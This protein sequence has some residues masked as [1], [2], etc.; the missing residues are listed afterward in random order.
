M[1]LSDDTRRA[2][3]ERL[4]SGELQVTPSAVVE[5]LR[6]LS[7][8]DGD[9]G[10]PEIWA[11]RIAIIRK[12]VCFG[13]QSRRAL[14]ILRAIGSPE[15]ADLLDKRV[16]VSFPAIITSLAAPPHQFS[17]MELALLR[18]A[19]FGSGVYGSADVEEFASTLLLTP[20]E[21]EKLLR[22]VTVLSG[23]VADT[24]SEPRNR[25][26]KRVWSAFDLAAGR[27][28]AV[29]S[30]ADVLRPGYGSQGEGTIDG[31][32]I[33]GAM[34]GEAV[35]G[36]GGRYRTGSPQAEA[37]NTLIERLQRVEDPADTVARHTRALLSGSGRPAATRAELRIAAGAYGVGGAGGAVIPE[38][39]PM[40]LNPTDALAA[41]KRPGGSRGQAVGA[42]AAPKR[43]SGSF[44]IMV[45]VMAGF[46][47]LIALAGGQSVLGFLFAFVI[48]S[49]MVTL[50]RSISAG[51][52]FGVI[53]VIGGFIVGGMGMAW[54]WVPLVAGIIGAIMISVDDRARKRPDVQL[55]TEQARQAL[56]G[57]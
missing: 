10:D 43:A 15:F 27:I 45:F 2:L 47:G 11:K 42:P 48:A 1:N 37:A 53:G 56:N 46:G 35:R 34:L 14:E 52:L 18:R 49:G 24:G 33:D 3:A 4:F 25:A 9:G 21:S 28:E 36:L 26:E 55:P 6:G 50:Y 20:G 57:R 44:A 41:A 51:W 8:S 38:A 29:H 40:E 16:G 22:G 17:Q 5:G 12:L 23:D 39:R 7:D 32:R 30:I 13:P 31:K 54:G 19:F